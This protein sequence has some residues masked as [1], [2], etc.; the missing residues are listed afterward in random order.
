MGMEVCPGQFVLHFGSNCRRGPARG[1]EKE[2]AVVQ[3]VILMCLHCLSDG[4]NS[5]EVRNGGYLKGWQQS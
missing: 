4:G 2:H 1:A 3:Y 5:G